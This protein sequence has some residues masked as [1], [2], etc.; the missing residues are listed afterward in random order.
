MA[1]SYDD[2]VNNVVN[3]DD[4]SNDESMQRKAQKKRGNAS[5]KTSNVSTTWIPGQPFY[6]NRKN[7]SRF[8]DH[9]VKGDVTNTANCIY[10]NGTVSCQTKYGTGTLSGHLERCDLSPFKVDKNQKVITLETETRVK[11]D[12]TTETV[13]IPKAWGFNPEKARKALAK[14]IIVDELPFRFVEGEGFQ[15]FCYYMNPQFKIPS[16]WTCARDCYEYF[17]EERRVLEKYFAKANCRVCLTTDLWTSNQNLTYMCLTAHWIDAA[18]KLNKR[19]INFCPIS[20]HTGKVIGRTV[21]KCLSTWDLKNILTVTVDNAT[22]ND[23]AIDYLRKVFNNSECDVLGGQYLHMRCASH[24]LNLVVKEGLKYLDKSI[25]KI[26]TLV[27]YCKASPSRMQKFLACVAEE[28]LESKSMLCLDVETRWNSTYLMLE[29]AIKFKKAFGRLL[30]MDSAL[31]RDMSKI[32]EDLTNDDWKQVS[33][34]LPF[35]KIFY[36]ATLKLSAS[37]YVTSNDY[38]EVIFGVG[39]VIKQGMKDEKAIVLMTTKMKEKYD[40]YWG[41]IDNLN[42]LLFVSLFL[43]PRWKMTY[44]EFIIKQAYGPIDGNI[45]IKR[46]KSLLLSLYNLYNDSPPKP[47]EVPSSSSRSSA[48]T[49]EPSKSKENP[50]SDMFNFSAIFGKKFEMEMGV[51]EEETKNELEKYMDEARERKNP[52]FDILEWWKDNARRYPVLAK[53]AR[54]VLAIA[55]S[56]VASEAAFSTGGRILDFFSYLFGYKNGGGTCMYARLASKFSDSTRY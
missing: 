10:C 9:F 47:K 39:E 28:K 53:I 6:R 3:V 50:E 7:A 15:E 56:S 54:D 13:S 2:S 55:V 35:L 36:D 31:Q 42:L 52:S 1:S 22:A 8:W 11:D 24:I 4:D 26:R 14:M 29:S 40:K 51:E 16:R 19:I 32:G 34:F 21:E 43:D 44:V 45:L 5:P 30:V 25:V 12:G 23:V 41:N 20:G 18:W 48:S 33:Y 46:I 27:K 17:I 37:R 49:S 38:V